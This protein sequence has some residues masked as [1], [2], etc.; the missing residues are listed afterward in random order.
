MRKLEQTETKSLELKKEYGKLFKAMSFGPDKSSTNES[1]P[2]IDVRGLKLD[3]LRNQSA[4]FDPSSPFK[5]H[6]VDELK[7]TIDSIRNLLFVCPQQAEETLN[8]ISSV[9]FKNDAGATPRGQS[10]TPASTR[11]SAEQGNQ[12]ARLDE[13]IGRIENTVRVSLIKS[14]NEETDS[15]LRSLNPEVLADSVEEPHSAKMPLTLLE[16]TLMRNL[17]INKLM[18]ILQKN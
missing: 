10:D 12:L 9:V 8:A 6:E 1:N 13:I 17:P 2:D 5:N 16:K 15:S 7:T 3:F 4:S 11:L 14:E 18:T